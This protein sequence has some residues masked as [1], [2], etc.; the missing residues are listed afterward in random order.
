MNAALKSKAGAIAV[1]AATSFWT[2][3]VEAQ[4]LPA[5][6][7]SR[8]LDAVL[9]PIDDNVRQ[10]F[11][12]TGVA[13]GVLVIATQP[14][15]AADSAGILPGDVIEFVSGR[16]IYTPIELDEIA[17]YSIGKGLGMLDYSLW[18]AGSITVTTTEITSEYW[19]E[20]ISISEVSS[21]ESYS[22]ESF[23]YSEF[24]SEYSSE[25]EASYTS[26]ESE[27][28]QTVSSEEFEQ[29]MAEESTDDLSASDEL[30]QQMTED[31][32]DDLSASDEAEC[33]GEIV[34]GVC[35]EEPIDDSNPDDGSLDDAGGD[36]VGDAGGDE[37][38]YDDVGGDDGGDA[39]GDDGGE[40]IEE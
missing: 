7:V 2:A 25:M 17:Y 3:S 35:A 34:D 12:I 15:G 23:S 20:S 11:G 29:Q 5:P 40:I 6:Y 22:Y 37:G 14:R 28:E 39:G 19:Y 1:L 8:A 30:D 18:R 9:L 16:R 26:S 24:Y 27:I 13:S 36:D 10:V 31:S 21:W 38:S 4:T 33:V 32:T